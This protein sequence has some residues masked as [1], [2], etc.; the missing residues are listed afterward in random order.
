MQVYQHKGIILGAYSITF[1]KRYDRGGPLNID[2]RQSSMFYGHPNNPR[3]CLKIGAQ[4]QMILYYVVRDTWKGYGYV[5]ILEI[6]TEMHHVSCY[7]KPAFCN[8][9]TYDGNTLVELRKGLRGEEQVM[10]FTLGGQ[11]KIK[12]LI[13]PS[14]NYV[15]LIEFGPKIKTYCLKALGHSMAPPVME[16]V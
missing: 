7:W 5:N 6:E 2:Y 16:R 9:L 15:N 12:Q 13:Q 14:G 4:I 1:T 11:N 8:Q 3:I 10:N